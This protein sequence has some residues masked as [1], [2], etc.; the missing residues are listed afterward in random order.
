MW[1]AAT[2]ALVLG[3]VPCLVVAMRADAISAVAGLALAGVL[4]T[5]ALETMTVAFKSQSFIELAVVL[6]PVSLVGSLAFIR[7]L[8]RR[9]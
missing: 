6:V 5:L 1:T 2:F 4:A 9:R 8:E 3:F 7:H